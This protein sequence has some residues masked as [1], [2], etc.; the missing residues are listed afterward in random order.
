MGHLYTNCC[1][2]GKRRQ[3]RRLLLL[4][5][6]SAID[7]CLME[8]SVAWVEHILLT[9]QLYGRLLLGLLTSMHSRNMAY[10]LLWGW[11]SLRCRLKAAWMVGLGLITLRR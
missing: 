3:H 8:R 1:L 5:E 7:L 11:C 4:I 6:T 2:L 9:A 10:K